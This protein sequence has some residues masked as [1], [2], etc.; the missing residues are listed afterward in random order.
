MKSAVKGRFFFW[1]PGHAFAFTPRRVPLRYTACG[2]SAR[3]RQK[4]ELTAGNRWR[5]NRYQRLVKNPYYRFGT[6]S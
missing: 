4:A 1:A 6:S 2:V 5:G 3:P